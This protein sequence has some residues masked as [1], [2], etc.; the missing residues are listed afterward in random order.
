ME[1]ECSVL[2]SSVERNPEPATTQRHIQRVSRTTIHVVNSKI[3]FCSIIEQVTGT[4]NYTLGG[5][6]IIPGQ[7]PRCFSLRVSVGMNCC[8]LD[9]PH[10]AFRQTLQFAETN[11]LYMYCSRVIRFLHPREAVL[12]RGEADMSSTT[13]GF[14]TDLTRHS[15]IRQALSSSS[16]ACVLNVAREPFEIVAVNS[17]WSKLCCYSPEEAL[18]K[19]R[20][21]IGEDVPDI[22]GPFSPQPADPRR[23]PRHPWPLLPSTC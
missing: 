20:K 5:E 12:D 7:N 16:T 21:H 4:R 18:Y 11:A 14:D 23:R 19:N 22:H 8:K 2:L 3:N 17:A 1:R 15:S 6:L 10:V 9:D 13:I